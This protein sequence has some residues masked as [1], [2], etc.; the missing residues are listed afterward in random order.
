VPPRPLEQVL[1]GKPPGRITEVV[2]RM[3]AIESTLPPTDGVAAFTR[4]YRA[5][6]EAIAD[7]GTGTAFEDVRTMRWLEVVFA[8]HYFAAL[9]NAVLGGPVPRA[10]QPLFAARAKRG[11]HPL[12]FALAGMN[13]HIN[14]DLPVALV[15]TCLAR[16]LVPRRSSPQQRDFRRVNDVLR[17]TEARVKADLLRGPF[18]LADE[19][20]GQLDDVVAMWNVERAREAAWLNSEALWAL[21]PSKRLSAD[22]LRTLDRM[23]GFAGR[24]LLRPIMQ[25]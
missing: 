11:I 18:A 25:P 24:G 15:E 3:R 19:A 8:N 1:A 13:A 23:V 21:R 9:R 2:A 4:L 10:W 5:V 20:L 16:K 6:T 7:S 17:A 12:Q 14:R 22:F